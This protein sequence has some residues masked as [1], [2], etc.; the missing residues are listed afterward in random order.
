MPR[1]FTPHNRPAANQFLEHA[2]IA[3]VYALKLNPSRAQRDFQT[4]I[5][6]H[7]R[8]HYVTGQFTACFQIVSHNPHGR[9]PI[10]KIAY[11]VDKERA[12]SI[13]VERYAKI[14][15][16]LHHPSLQTLD[17]QRAALAINVISVRLVS[18]REDARACPPK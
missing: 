4:D 2:L 16:L 8:N 13:T 6:H 10:D 15:S 3:D 9:V 17:M 7:G 12:I 11:C 18:D 1:L 14:C 5:A